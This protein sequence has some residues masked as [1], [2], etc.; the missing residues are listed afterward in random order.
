MSI[1][2]RNWYMK[3]RKM[4]YS[5]ELSPYIILQRSSFERWPLLVL[6]YSIF[7][8]ISSP[9]SPTAPPPQH[10]SLWPLPPGS[11]GCTL[12]K[13][14]EACCDLTLQ[15]LLS[16]RCPPQFQLMRT[17]AWSYA[18]RRTVAPA[19]RRWVYS[20]LLFFALLTRAGQCANISLS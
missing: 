6:I 14:F 2:M 13:S 11:N 3:F 5:V 4:L 8:F 15:Q 1:S 17:N 19:S 20:C 10:C 18:S 16:G 7:C 12:I 9:P